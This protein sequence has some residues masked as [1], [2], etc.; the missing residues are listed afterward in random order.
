MQLSNDDLQAIQLTLEL[1]FVTT[2]LLLLIGTP[3]A[4]LL[5]RWQSRLKWFVEIIVTLPLVLPPTVIGFYLLLLFSPNQG[6]GGWL[7]DYFDVQLVFTFS[8]LVIASIIYSLPFTVQPLQ[9]AFEQWGRSMDESAQMIGANRWQRFFFLVV[10]YARSAFVTAMTLTFSH[11]LGEFGI[12][13]MIGGN[14]P[15]ETQVASIALFEHVESMQYENAHALAL[16]LIII[17]VFLLLAIKWMN[18]R[19]RTFFK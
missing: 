1:S 19:S 14:I 17:S 4:W 10:P 2:L 11:T 9:N 15:G 18:A 7:S 6:I 13:L 8:G 12:V 5:S 16:T 3:I